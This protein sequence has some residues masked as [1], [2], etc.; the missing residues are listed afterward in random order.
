[1]ILMPGITL[2]VELQILIVSGRT[3]EER[4]AS[5]LPRLAKPFRQAELS[6]SIA[7]LNY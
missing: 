2:A 6:N 1:M 3:Q 5:D 7:S 4:V